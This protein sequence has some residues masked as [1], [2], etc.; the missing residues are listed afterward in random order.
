MSFIT[1]SCPT[2][3]RFHGLSAH[4]AAAKLHFSSLIAANTDFKQEAQPMTRKRLSARE[5]MALTKVRY[6]E[7]LEYLT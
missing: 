5:A 3:G 1:L 2:C 6:K 7:T 4:E